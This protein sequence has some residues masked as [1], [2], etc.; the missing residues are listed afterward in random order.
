MEKA[1][2]RKAAKDG[3]AWGK[4]KAGPLPAGRAAGTCS[5]VGIGAAGKPVP[6]PVSPRKGD[7]AAAADRSNDSCLFRRRTGSAAETYDPVRRPFFIAVAL[8]ASGSLT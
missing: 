1:V 8:A 7:N 2:C 5:V 4:G 6:V 3:G